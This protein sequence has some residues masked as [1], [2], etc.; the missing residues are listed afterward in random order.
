[1]SCLSEAE[2]DDDDDDAAIQPVS[3]ASIKT[4]GIRQVDVATVPMESHSH[5]WSASLL[6]CSLLARPPAALPAYVV[7]PFHSF[8]FFFSHQ[9]NPP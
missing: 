6:L 7:L 1:M 5:S 2:Q 4:D 9:L 3:F 8:F